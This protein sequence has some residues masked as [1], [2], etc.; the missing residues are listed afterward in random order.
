MADRNTI[1]NNLDIDKD[2]WV[3][4]IGG[5]PSPFIRSDILA[6]KFLLDN[7]QRASSLVVDRPLVICDAHYLP[8]LDGSFDYVFCSQIL[9]H[10]ENPQLFLREIARVGRKGYIETPNEIRE[11]MFGWPFHKWIVDKDENGLVLRENDVEQAFGLFFH[12]LQWENYEFS[13]FCFT[14]HDLLNICYEWHG[15]PNFR[16][17]KEGEYR[18]PSQKVSINVDDVKDLVLSEPYK[19]RLSNRIRILRKVKKGMPKKLKKILRSLFYSP[20][21]GHRHSEDEAMNYIFSVLACPI[22]K[23]KVS[24]K[25]HKEDEIVCVKCG[26]NYELRNG[27]PFMLVE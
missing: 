11:R 20:S 16:F 10:L 17:A 26:Q 15:K 9:E 5:G 7:T 21:Y 13:R 18:L 14:A 8:F 27:I 19:D 1:L 6:D 23:R 22:C 3:L 24:I 2:D 25:P 12:R 4:E